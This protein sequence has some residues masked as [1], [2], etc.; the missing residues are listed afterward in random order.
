MKQNP[1]ACV[2]GGSGFIGRRIVRALAAQGY[3]VKVATRIPEQAYD[4]KPAGII[5]Q[6]VPVLC[7][8]DDPESLHNLVRGCEMVVNCVGILRQ[9][10]RNSF[11]R[12]HT[13]LPAAIAKACANTGVK[14]LV[15]ISALA[16]DRGHSKYAKS[17]LE[18]E[19]AV[20]ANFPR[21]IILR[22]SVVFG[23]D[24]NF[25]NMF[26]R[27]AQILPC[28]PLFG[29]GHTKFQPV[30]VGDVAEAA[31]HAL[32]GPA[33]FEGKIF[34]LGGPDTLSL[35]EIYEVIFA[36]ISRRRLMVPLPWGL[37]K[38]QAYF[39][40]MTPA[41]LITPDQVESLK[42]DNVVSPGMPGLAEMGIHAKSLKTIVPAYLAR[43][44][45][46]RRFADKKAA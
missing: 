28:L 34:E 17:K 1:T 20:L 16:A 39:I 27:L 18:G 43:H 26:A 38:T 46:G 13:D 42:T 37:A 21:A 33:A 5:G 32:Q 22:P 29:G 41:P 31:I 36:A 11:A 6:I 30:Y 10:R 35:R 24:D 25:F 4:L 15:H 40:A 19:K 8:Y 44:R 45:K 3:R 14:R 12:I 2:F 23:D 9:R 7:R